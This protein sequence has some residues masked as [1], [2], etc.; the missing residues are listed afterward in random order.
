[1]SIQAILLPVFVQALLVVI[2]A[3]LM[4][5]RRRQA[6]LAREVRREEI[7]LGQKNWP[8]RA[9]AASNAYGSQFELPMLFFAIVPLAIITRKAD[10]LFVVLS[11]LFVATRYAHAAIYVIS[12]HIPARFCA[13]SAGVLVMLS[14]WGV[15]AFRILLVP[16]TI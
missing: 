15:F 12:N 11:W 9:Q 2:L 6:V 8:P 16:A 7:I 5:T 1:M 3:V 10:F 13:F 14:M 4:G